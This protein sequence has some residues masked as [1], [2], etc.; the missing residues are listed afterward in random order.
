MMRKRLVTMLAAA[1]LALTG[2]AGTVHAQTEGQGNPRPGK[3]MQMHRMQ[4]PSVDERLARMGKRLDLTDEQK[5]KIKPLMEEQERQMKATFETTHAK[6]REILTPD[7]QKK[8][9]ERPARPGECRQGPP[10]GTPAPPPPAP[11]K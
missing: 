8:F 11:Q 4:R 9:D 7:Q 10:K 3:Q 5:A 1:L 6:I 2:A